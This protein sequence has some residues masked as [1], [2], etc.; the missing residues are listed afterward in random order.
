MIIITVC[1]FLL[2]SFM[3]KK[4][5]IYIVSWGGRETRKVFG[6]SDR[7]TRNRLIHSIMHSSIH[8]HLFVYLR[9]FVILKY[10]MQY[11][12]A[13]NHIF[14]VVVLERVLCE[15]WSTSSVSITMGLWSVSVLTMPVW[16][17]LTT[18]LSKLVQ[19]RSSRLALWVVQMLVLVQEYI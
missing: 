9:A 2:K 15:L 10:F 3:Q 4:H 12:V 16:M 11:A 5:F 1:V 7:T 8:R 18:K 19:K 14:A 13:F 17:K 6:S